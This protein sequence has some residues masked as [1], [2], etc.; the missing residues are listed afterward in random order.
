MKEAINTGGPA[1][2]VRLPIPGATHANNEPIPT[3]LHT[4]MSLR[5][6]FIAHAPAEPQEWFRGQMPPPPR[7]RMAKPDDLTKEES[8]E[9]AAWGEF[10]DAHDMKQPRARMIAEDWE[11][12]QKE[13]A[14]WNRERTKQR[15]VQWPAA[16]AD[17]MLEQRAK[18]GAA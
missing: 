9:L 6:Y 15:F 12:H 3:E 2:P 14:A 11:R 10:I 4:G 5:D 16:W 1:F 13:N 18:G 7:Q 8:E 17:A